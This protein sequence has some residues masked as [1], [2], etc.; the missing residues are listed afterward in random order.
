MTFIFNADVAYRSP[1]TMAIFSRPNTE[2]FAEYIFRSSRPELI[3]KKGACKNFAKLTATQ[4]CQ[5]ILFNK[6]S[7]WRPATLI[8][9][10]LSCV[11]GVVL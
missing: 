10:G 5:S 8:K 9:K 2:L 1:Q 7:G 3:L 11:Q 6:V 4:L